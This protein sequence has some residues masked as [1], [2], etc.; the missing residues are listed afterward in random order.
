M[1]PR[2]SVS[3][4]ALSPEEKM[5]QTDLRNENLFIGIPNEPSPHENRV[6]LTPAS[7]I[8]LVAHGHHIVVESSAGLRAG[9][10]DHDY[11]EAGA[12][13]VYSQQQVYAANILLKVAPLDDKE[14]EL[15]R[16]NQLVIAPIHVPTL[17]EQVV[18]RLKQKRVTAIAMD[19]I[20]D[21]S[22]AFPIVRAMSEIAGISAILTAA[23]LLS[24]QSKIDGTPSSV[25]RLQ[26]ISLTPHHRIRMSTLLRS[27]WQI[28]S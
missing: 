7:V 23:E 8:A 4:Y 6:A 3:E 26:R 11:S 13:I 10:T 20:K 17:S 15:L 21:S 24:I 28:N 2:F 19:Y 27:I 25:T 22:G 18:T 16:T 12:E 9:F 5:A 14:V 1:N